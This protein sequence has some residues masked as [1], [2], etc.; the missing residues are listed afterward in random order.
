EMA[1]AGKVALRLSA[2]RVPLLPGALEYASQGI[3]TGGADRNRSHLRDKVSL[4]D[5]ISKEIEHVLFD[6]QTSGGLLMAVAPEKA[7]EVEA[8]FAAAELS[9]W[10]V[11]EVAKGEGVEVL[12]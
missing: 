2:G 10:Q 8:R 6:P 11:G 3:V 4:S 7:G 12:P 9:V 5:K 1:A